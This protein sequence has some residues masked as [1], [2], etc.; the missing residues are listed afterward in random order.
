MLDIADARGFFPALAFGPHSAKPE[1]DYGAE[2]AM[3]GHIEAR[4]MHTPD[5]RHIE[6]LMLLGTRIH[7]IAAVVGAV[8]AF[9]RKLVEGS[10]SLVASRLAAPVIRVAYCMLV[11]FVE[12]T[13]GHIPDVSR[14]QPSLSP[15]ALVL[16]LSA[17]PPFAL[18]PLVVSL[19][20]FAWRRPAALPLLFPASLSLHI[21]SSGCASLQSQDVRMA[22]LLLQQAQLV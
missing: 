14:A 7:S 12:L 22:A 10:H 11:H 17:L 13:D 5:A 15:F 9:V 1:L 18:L 6:E 3:L 19:H 4:W 20:L 8:Q 21:H 16:C 2:V